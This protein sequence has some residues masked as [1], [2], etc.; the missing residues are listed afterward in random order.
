MGK[1]AGR[2]QQRVLEQQQLRLQQR[3]ASLLDEESRQQGRAA[4]A[5]PKKANVREL[6]K[7]RPQNN[8]LLD[9]FNKPG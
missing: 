3:A 8:S 9:Y 6:L 4:T 7:P 5:V 2:T 1:A